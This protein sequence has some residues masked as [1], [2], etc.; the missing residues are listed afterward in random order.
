[1]ADENRRRQ[2]SSSVRESYAIWASMACR[3]I[4]LH[5]WHA[6]GH[7]FLGQTL[8]LSLNRSLPGVRQQ[9][10]SAEEI[11]IRNLIDELAKICWIQTSRSAKRRRSEL[12]ADSRYWR[13]PGRRDEERKKFA[14]LMRKLEHFRLRQGITKREL[15]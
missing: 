2:V 12:M 11:A 14:S 3:K 5:R 1:M 6:R 10:R 8:E 15:A 7:D 13:R 4:A 9:R